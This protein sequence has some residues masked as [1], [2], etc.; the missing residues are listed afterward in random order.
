MKPPH[1]TQNEE[2]GHWPQAGSQGEG[3]QGPR[4]GRGPPT[5]TRLK[6]AA[7]SES[8]PPAGSPLRA[9]FGVAH[10]SPSPA[11]PFGTLV[12]LTLCGA[13]QLPRAA[14]TQALFPTPHLHSAQ[15][16]KH[17]VVWEVP[18]W[19]SGNEADEDP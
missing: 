15:L 9:Q 12:S 2:V 4:T 5:K 7:G 11:P 8:L 6:A 1:S 10:C 17:K 14:L 18:L 16:K 19:C 3:R 13:A